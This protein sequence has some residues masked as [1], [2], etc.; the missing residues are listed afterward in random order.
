MPPSAQNSVSEYRPF[1]G[2]ARR[3]QDNGE[4]V[5][6]DDDDDDTNRIIGENQARAEI[7]EEYRSIITASALKLPDHNYTRYLREATNS[8][9]LVLTCMIEKATSNAF[10]DWDEE[11]PSLV[12][13]Y[14]NIKHSLEVLAA[15]DPQ[16]ALSSSSSDVDSEKT[17]F[18]G[19]QEEIAPTKRTRTHAQM[20]TAA[21]AR[22]AAARD[23]AARDTQKP[24]RR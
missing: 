9:L 12:E 11:M 24:K 3:L 2:T 19:S 23:V 13:Q 21:A 5:T 22:D 16:E 20:T 14:V 7:L 4:V 6:I 15:Y 8:F 1:R 17:L 10:M 18:F